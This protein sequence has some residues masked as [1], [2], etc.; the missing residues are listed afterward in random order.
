M[1]NTEPAAEKRTGTVDRQDSVDRT[2]Q[3]DSEEIKG[4][5]AAATPAKRRSRFVSMFN[6]PAIF[7]SSGTFS[8]IFGRQKDVDKLISNSENLTQKTISPTLA[9]EPV[10][11]GELTNLYDLYDLN[12]PVAEGGHAIIYAANDRILNRQVAIKSLRKE[13][14]NDN[15]TRN[16]FIAE[17]KLTAQ[18][19]HP[20][21]VPIYSLNNDEQNGLFLAMKMINGKTLFGYLNR[22]IS[23]YKLD[24]MN[25]YDERKSLLYRLDVFLKICDA[26]SYAHSQGIIHCDLKPE[27]IMIGEFRETYVMDWGI[28]KNVNNITPAKKISGTPRYMSPEVIR[29]EKID[30]RSDIFSL[31]VILFEIVT[32]APAFTGETYNDVMNYIRNNEISEVRHRFNA[33]IDADLQA[34][35]RKA[36]RNNRNLRYQTVDELSMDIRRY[37]DGQEVLARPD[38]FFGKIVRRCKAHVRLLIFFVAMLLVLIAAGAAYAVFDHLSKALQAQYQQRAFAQCYASTNDVA[39]RM[40]RFAYGIMCDLNSIAGQAGFFLTHLQIVQPDYKKY[41]H[42]DLQDPAK[43]PADTSYSKLYR[44]YVSLQELSF[45]TPD[46][47]NIDLAYQVINHLYPIQ[48]MIKQLFIR[49]NNLPAE[50][51]GDPKIPFDEKISDRMLVRWIYAGFP[52]GLIMVYPGGS[53]FSDHYDIRNSPWYWDIS[54]NKKAFWSDPYIDADEKHNPISSCVVPILGDNGEFLGFVAL[55]MAMNKLTDFLRDQQRQNLNLVSQYIINGA[56]LT[57]IDTSRPDQY[58]NYNANTGEIN[59]RKFHDPKL[60]RAIKAKRYGT[61]MQR[62]VNREVLYCFSYIKSLDWFYVTKINLKF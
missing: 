12:N 22:V 29:C 61:V 19:D 53:F 10:D 50:S 16:N 5:A 32:L 14:L 39:S 33:A 25:Q 60:F 59:L 18:L 56:G 36:T 13:M 4:K 15:H 52:D 38:G 30:Q 37:L 55:D 3:M 7:S 11:L 51:V 20:S 45:H 9:D 8:R 24:G 27:N 42:A 40:D 54:H 49:S 48:S 43:A 34:I 58:N 57:V 6:V 23:L 35:I 2:I 41:F 47:K 21:I 44:Q 31:G 1:P 17:S 62:E 46:K 26:M 28:A